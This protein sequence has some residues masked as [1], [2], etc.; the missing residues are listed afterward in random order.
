[1]LKPTTPFLFWAAYLGFNRV[2]HLNVADSKVEQPDAS[3]PERN[4]SV[5]LPRI[6]SIWALLRTRW[7][8]CDTPATGKHKELVVHVTESRIGLPT[9]KGAQAVRSGGCGR[10]F[11]NGVN[12]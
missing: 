8:T 9:N 12:K 11:G 4:H 6:G 7:K 3:Q 1:M 10:H 5:H 2:Y